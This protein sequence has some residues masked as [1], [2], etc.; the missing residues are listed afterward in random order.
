[1]REHF[2]EFSVG[3]KVLLVI[4]G[5]IFGAAMALLFGFV[6]KILWNWLMTDLF[7][8][9]S[10]TYW[11]AW[12]IAFLSHILFKGGFSGHGGSDKS[13]KHREACGPQLA[14]SSSDEDWKSDFKSCGDEFKAEWKKEFRKEFEKE[15]KKHQD[16]KDSETVDS[17]N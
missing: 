3:K 4:G 12:G 13:K 14:G 15:L 5:V 8:L 17:G 10:I 9:P 2:N 6:V 11:Q 7:N 1:M 16:N